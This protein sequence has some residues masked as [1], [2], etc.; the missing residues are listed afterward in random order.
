MTLG[1]EK[2]ELSKAAGRV[3][4]KAVGCY[5]P[6]V[7]IL[8]PGERIKEENLAQLEAELKAGAKLFGAEG[9]M[10]DVVSIN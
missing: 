8:F 2:I 9:G 10:I 4:A 7:A 5:P 6:G 3:C 1:V